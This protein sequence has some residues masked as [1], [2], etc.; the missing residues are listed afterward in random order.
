MLRNQPLV[1]TMLSALVLCAM[2]PIASGSGFAIIEQ[3]PSRIGTAFAGATANNSDAGAIYWNP[4]GIANLSNVEVIVGINAILPSFTFEDK[5]STPVGGGN[6]G[7]AGVEAWVPN[8]YAAMGISDRITAGIGVFAP[9]GLKTKYDADW[10]GR[11]AA[12][13]TELVTLDINPTLAIRLSESLSV[14]AGFTAE[15]ADATLIS[16]VPLAPGVDGLAT[17]EGDDWS[18]G[19]NLGAMCTLP[20]GVRVGLSYRSAIEHEIDGSISIGPLPTEGGT[21]ALELP[22]TAAIGLH[23]PLCDAVSL[24][25]DAAWTGWSSFED[26]TVLK[27]DGSVL[28]TKDESWEDTWRVAVGLTYQVNDDLVLRTGVAYDQTPVPD[29]A[30]RTARIPDADRT[31]LA[32]GAGLDLTDALTVDVGYVHIWFNDSD[33]SD[34]YG[35]GTALV[36]TYEGDVDIVS[37]QLKWAI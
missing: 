17:V 23:V 22:E 24:Q 32:A 8:F 37:L 3:S 6:G 7:D 25:A 35:P 27:D 13:E 36:G 28:S 30:H 31:W 34:A 33:V 9:Y 21:A 26:L 20:C 19:Y 12:V 16:A 15:R 14:G 10:I 2:V 29:A 5:G 4:A 18:Y 11:Y 1:L